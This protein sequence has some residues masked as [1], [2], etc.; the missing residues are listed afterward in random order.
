VHEI[1]SRSRDPFTADTSRTGPDSGCALT[2]G[3]NVGR[4]PGTFSAP[5]RSFRSSAEFSK[6]QLNFSKVSGIGFGRDGNYGCALSRF[7]KTF[8]TRPAA[9]GLTEVESE[10]LISDKI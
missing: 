8:H 10:L 5:A 9:L 6:S 7:A 1:F 2:H 4:G 3:S